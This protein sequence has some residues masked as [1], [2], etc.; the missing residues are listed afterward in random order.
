MSLKKVHFSE[1]TALRIVNGAQEGYIR[2]RD[3]RPVRL[4]CND[5]RGEYPIVGLIEMEMG[6]LVSTWTRSGKH[7]A[8][9][10]DRDCADLILFVEEGGEK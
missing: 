4:L 6:D 3:N 1:K 2:T 8:R 10:S 7:D 5:A 9:R